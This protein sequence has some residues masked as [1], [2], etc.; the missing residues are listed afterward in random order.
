M[1]KYLA[2][3][4]EADTKE[5]DNVA[6]PPVQKV[7]QVQELPEKELK[8]SSYTSYTSYTK[9]NKNGTRYT[10]SEPEE[11]RDGFDR[12]ISSPA[13]KG[14]TVTRWRQFIEDVERF[15][16]DWAEKAHALG[17]TAVDVF[18]LHPEAPTHRPDSAGLIWL[19]SGH[20]VAAM[21]GS[22]AVIKI[23]GNRTQTFHRRAQGGVPA[24]KL[25]EARN[26]S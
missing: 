5:A 1:N 14:I 19:L 11:W 24:W 25:T 22:E 9:E 18:G 15:M 8:P 13:P 16:T 2:A 7:Y 12:L 21:S 3:A 17:W 4:L 26:E 10:I 6:A 23:S 20:E